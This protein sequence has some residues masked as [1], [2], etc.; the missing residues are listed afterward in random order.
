MLCG[1]Q[2][3]SKKQM[4]QPPPT[5]EQPSANHSRNSQV[6]GKHTR[7]TTDSV[8]QNESVGVP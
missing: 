5:Q 7:S 3:M 1:L 2:I 6:S 8:I 4:S